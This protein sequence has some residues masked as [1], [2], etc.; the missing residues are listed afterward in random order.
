MTT[1]TH[2]NYIEEISKKTIQLLSSLKKFPLGLMAVVVLS[3]FFRLIWL[4]KVPTGISDDELGF[5]INAKAVFLTGKDINGIWSPFSLS[6]I[7]G[8]CPQAELPC[9]I[10]AP[11]IGPLPLSLFTAK[12]FYVVISTLLIVLLYLITSRFINRQAA[13]FV[14][15]V[16]ALNPWSIIFGRTAYEAPLAIFFYLLAFYVLIIAKNW[17]ILFAFIPLLIGFYSYQGTKL[18]FVP[19]AFLIALFSWYVLSQKRYFKQYLVLFILCLSLFVYFIFSVQHQST[20]TRLTELSTP[21]SPMYTMTVDN[22]RRLSIKTP[23]TSLFSN[24]LV[25]FGKDSIDK[26]LGVFSTNFLF[27]TGEGRSTFSLWYHGY[28]YYLDFFF[29]I[30]G[31]CVLFVKRKSLWFLLSSLVLIAPIPT[32]VSNV[33]TGFAALRSSLIYPLFIILIG[34]GIWYIVFLSRRKVYFVTVLSVLMVLYGIQVLNF[35]NIYFFRNPIY[36]SEAYNLSSR[37]LSKY[38]QLADVYG[39]KIIVISDN[40]K[41]NFY[42]YLFDANLYNANTARGISNL[43]QQSKYEY[44]NV[45]FTQ[46]RDTLDFSGNTTIVGV[47]IKK[48]GSLDFNTPQGNLAIPQLSDG[49]PIFR[50]VNDTICSKYHESLSHFPYNFSFSDFAVE[51]LPEE[52]FCEKFITD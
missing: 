22:E 17:K 13:L 44:N 52:R 30:V 23:L 5:I 40:P 38:I 3:L 39:R 14:G 41:G 12:L 7:M 18:I 6:S 29:L 33:G 37:V 4:D 1:R 42:H 49:G 48:C 24:K 43:I 25:A 28:F 26:Y 21:N 20:R 32:V 51:N 35:I 9:L 47:A 19:Y 31:F 27:L 2:V 16:G 15:L 10:I 11:V 45:T 8:G 34:L 50:I 36:N 46:C